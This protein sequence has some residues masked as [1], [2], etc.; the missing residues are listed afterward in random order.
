MSY[1]LDI[2]PAIFSE[3]SMS[4]GAIAPVLI[5]VGLMMLEQ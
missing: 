5:M 3:I 1:I 4:A 2:N